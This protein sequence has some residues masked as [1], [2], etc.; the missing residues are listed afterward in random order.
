MILRYG[1]RGLTMDDLATDLG[2]SKKTLYKSFPS[3][4][5]LISEIVDRIVENEKR[6]FEEEVSKRD[7]W[8]E[9][10]EMMLTIYTLE[11]IPYRLVDEL[12]RYFPKEKEKIE[13]L[14]DFRQAMILP[15]LVQGQKDGDIRPDLD[16]EIISLVL[17]KL[18]VDLTDPKILDRHEHTVKQLLEQMKRLFF[19]GIL[20]R[21][22]NGEK[23]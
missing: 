6:I 11:D 19:Y 2:M 12:Y 23:R 22:N 21:K 7:T 13:D 15:L 18:F 16:P 1:L 4:N 3:K 20:E 10:L 9:K 8:F 14:A 5:Q 17:H